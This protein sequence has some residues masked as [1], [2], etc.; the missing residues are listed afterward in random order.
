MPRKSPLPWAQSH[1]AVTFVLMAIL[2]FS[3]LIT[4]GVKFSALR[5]RAKAL[6]AKQSSSSTVK[7]ANAGRSAFESDKFDKIKS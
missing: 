2:P 5:S 3:L 6:L 4:A 1:V 7:I